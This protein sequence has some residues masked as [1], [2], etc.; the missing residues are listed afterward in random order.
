MDRG[1]QPRVAYPYPSQAKLPTLPRKKGKI[2]T[3][4][5]LLVS[6]KDQLENT[7]LARLLGLK[8]TPFPDRNRE[9]C[10]LA[11]LLGWKQHPSRTETVKNIPLRAA[12]PQYTKHSQSPPL[13]LPRGAMTE[14]D[15]CNRTGCGVH[16]ER[17]GRTATAPQDNIFETMYICQDHGA[18][19]V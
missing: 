2:T 5:R 1:V 10:T 6:N 4:A 17:R 19:A 9:K 18:C 15:I 14:L 7:P 16:F 12:H 3:L 8:T 11:R 13:P